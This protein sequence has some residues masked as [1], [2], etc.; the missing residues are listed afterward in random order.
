M[1]SSA[2]V[3]PGLRYKQHAAVQMMPQLSKRAFVGAAVDE[4]I[5]LLEHIAISARA[6]A[7]RGSLPLLTTE[8]GSKEAT[9]KPMVT[10]GYLGSCCLSR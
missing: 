10:V 6:K 8:S 2:W 7:D 1:E 5:A 4:L 9:P 3:F